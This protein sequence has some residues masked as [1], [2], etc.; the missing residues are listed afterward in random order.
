MKA[1]AINGQDRQALASRLKS[2]YEAI[3][4]EENRQRHMLGAKEPPNQDLLDAR[5]DL[6]DAIR[7]L[8][9]GRE[10]P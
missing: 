5:L 4:R 1:Y 10:A 7:I 3:L 6:Q 8:A 2:C 9:N